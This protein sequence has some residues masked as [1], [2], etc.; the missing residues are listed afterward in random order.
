MTA[1]RPLDLDGPAAPPRRNGELAFEEPWESRAFGLALALDA[2]GTI[3]WEAF[4]QQL[5]A[6]IGAWEATHGVD[7]ESWSYWRCWQEALE[8]VLASRGVI[9]RADLDRRSEQLAALPAGHDHLHQAEEATAEESAPRARPR[10]VVVMPA[11]NAA[12]TLEQTVG[13]IPRDIVDEIILVDDKSSDNTLELAK[14]LDI[15]VIWHPHNVGYGANQ[16]TCYLD[17]LQRHPDVVVMLHPDGQYDA[18][19]IPDLIR[20]IVEGDADLVL[21]SRL[22]E[23]GMALSGGMPRYKYWANRFLTT[24]ENAALGTHLSEMHTGYRAYSRALLLGIPFLRNALDFSF[25]SELLMQAVHFGFRIAEI[26]ARSVYFEEA[27]SVGFKDGVIYGVK[28]LA[29]A[30]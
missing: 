22:A 8:T 3:E 25:D 28:T 15:R 21:G 23:P 2:A 18:S 11:L 24:L 9:D 19:L 17:A 16:K 30:G 7:D 13:L 14:K 5:I 6:T 10:V 12:Q 29:V 4:R 1:G 20:P 27:S 26:P